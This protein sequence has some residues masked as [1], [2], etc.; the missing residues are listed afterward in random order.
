MAQSDDDKTVFDPKSPAHQ[1]DRTRID[2]DSPV[3]R[4]EGADRT[5]IDPDSPAHRGHAEEERTQRMAPQAAASA[6]T[7]KTIVSQPQPAEGASMELPKFPPM[8]AIPTVALPTGY[9]L[10]EYRIDSVL[11]QGG[12]GITYLAVDVNL[13]SKVAIKEY[14]PEQIAYR[15]QDVSVSPRASE[16]NETYEEGLES[17]LVEARTLATFRHPHIVRVARFFEANNTAYMVLEYERGKSL[18]SWWRSRANMSENKILELFAPL[19]DGLAVV[20]EAGFLHRDIK[21]DN[22]YVRDE[23]GTL[24]LL[25][26]GAAVQ[27]AAKDR[28]EAATVVTPGFGP[29]EQYVNGDQGPWTDIYAF[30]ATLYWMISG[31]KPF[32]APDRLGAEDPL[33]SAVSI[34]KG[35]YSEKFLQAIDWA[36]KPH[37]KDRPRD[38]QEFRKV[39]YAEHPSMLN[40]Q[41][42]LKL[43]EGE[44]GGSDSWVAAFTSPRLL[45]SRVKRFGRGLTRPGSWPMAVKLTLAMVATALAPMLITANYNLNGS[46]ERVSQGELRNLEQLALSLAGRITQLLQDSKGLADYLAAD[47]DFVEYLRSPKADTTEAIRLKLVSLVKTNPEVQLA[48]VF[49]TSGTAVV[50]SDPQVMGRNFKFREYFKV[51]MEGRSF[52]TGIIVGAV[53]GQAGMF[54]SN[55]VRDP[56]T[57]AVIGAVVLRIKGS[58]V[59]TILEA[60]KTPGRAPFLIDG[61]GVIVHAPDERHVFK[62]LVPLSADVLKEIKADQRFRRDTIESVNMPDLARAMIGAKAPGNVS[63]RSTISGKEEIA[64]YSPVKGHDWVV[65]VTETREYFEGPL[66]Q[67]YDTVLKSVLIVGAVFLLFAMLFA[68]TIVRPIETL[69]S[70]AH[71]LKAGDYEK[72]NVKVTTG[73]EIGQLARVFNVMID[74][75]RQRDR[76]R[77]SAPKA[78]GSRTATT[79]GGG[80]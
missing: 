21:P 40:L 1:A 3:H 27:A 75:L 70:A 66:N 59:S 54:Y 10:H 51:A 74:V 30:G 60:S 22:I 67:L 73:D 9:R 17:Y 12:F 44:T 26:F 8:T 14:L 33:P 36:L 16:Y 29:I 43:G 49:D 53:A 37:A 58:A 64:G 78:R 5:R 63:Y 41:D 65:G 4:A 61:D 20:H 55:P 39:L 7:E 69:T 24:V 50:S 18:K 80:E 2:P 13:N 34:G 56:R 48:M 77:G 71:A 31:K 32:E 76:E 35:R 19:L 79:A 52:T 15:S 68:R 42:A 62:S 23:D 38:V 11:G 72:A 57:D 47:D 45:W 46:V 25:D 28:S 6:D